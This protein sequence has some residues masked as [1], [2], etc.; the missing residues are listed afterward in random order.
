MA[1][2]KGHRDVVERLLQNNANVDQAMNNG[3]EA[4]AFGHQD[5]VKN[6]KKEDFHGF[7][8]LS[9][10]H[11]ATSD[12]HPDIVN[13]TL[14]ISNG[15]ALLDDASNEF[16]LTPLTSAIKNKGILDTI[17]ERISLETTL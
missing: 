1:S 12:N 9:I 7:Q 4:S 16:N 2:K 5:I 8:N 6:F 10:L 13:L 11:I 14:N 15:K 3:T 17:F